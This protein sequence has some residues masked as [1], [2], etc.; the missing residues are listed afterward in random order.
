MAMKINK[1]LV[2]LTVLS[3]LLAV[4]GF[5]WNFLDARSPL[6]AGPNIGAAGLIFVGLILA[7]VFVANWAG[8]AW[9]Q[10]KRHNK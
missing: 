6:S 8:Q 10:R 9:Y 2:A 1:I 7:V 5:I 4:S 3:V